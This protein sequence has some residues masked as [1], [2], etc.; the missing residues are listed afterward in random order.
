MRLTEYINMRMMVHMIY[1]DDV[2]F[3]VYDENDVKI[4]EKPRLQLKQLITVG[5]SYKINRQVVRTRR[6]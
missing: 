3:P 6:I 5:F 2:L 1:D 4:G